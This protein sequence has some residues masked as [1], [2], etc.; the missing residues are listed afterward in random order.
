MLLLIQFDWES[1]DCWKL[2]GRI[3]SVLRF[4]YDYN[5]SG[6]PM[7]NDKYIVKMFPFNQQRDQVLLLCTFA[8]L[9]ARISYISSIYI[10]SH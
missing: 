7:M 9:T 10:L 8:G 2:Y 6:G 5:F 1:G 3:D 4:D